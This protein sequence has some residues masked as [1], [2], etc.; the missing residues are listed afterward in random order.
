MQLWFQCGGVMGSSNGERSPSPPWGSH[1][2]GGRT[3]HGRV[4]PRSPYD[5]GIISM[6]LL[7]VDDIYI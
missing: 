7:W 1:P 4:F 6:C 2:V 5:E 3:C